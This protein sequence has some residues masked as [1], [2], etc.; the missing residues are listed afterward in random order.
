MIILKCQ[1]SQPG[2]P[3]GRRAACRAAG[4][5]QG[6]GGVGGRS[7]FSQ[8]LRASSVLLSGLRQ[9]RDPRPGPDGHC[10]L[11][12]GVLAPV[13]SRPGQ[14]GWSPTIS[15]VPGCAEE[16]HAEGLV[17]GGFGAMCSAFD[18]VSSWFSYLGESTDSRR[19]KEPHPCLREALCSRALH[20]GWGGWWGVRGI[21]EGTASASGQQPVLRGVIAC[22]VRTHSLACRDVS[23]TPG[24]LWGCHREHSLLRQSP[25]VPRPLAFSLSPEALG[26]QCGSQQASLQ[27]QCGTQAHPAGRP[28]ACYFLLSTGGPLHPLSE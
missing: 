2:L 24:C 1:R 25:H 18:L 8:A 23:Q 13:G 27:P 10:V 15:C 5:Q 7:P 16:H 6:R 3:E 21:G 19:N 9:V 28:V 4:R 22:E 11:L 20:G 26:Q 14:A 17:S 12:D